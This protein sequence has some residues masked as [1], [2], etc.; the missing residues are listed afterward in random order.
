LFFE[1]S[2]GTPLWLPKCQSNCM[3]RTAKDAR[4]QGGDDLNLYIHHGS[5][6]FRLDIA[7]SLSGKAARE[8]EL[9]W[10][11][12]LSVIGSRV[13]VVAI[14]HVSSLDH[15]G[16]A[17][18]R[19]WQEAGA[20]FVAKSPLAKTLIGSII[21]QPVISGIG[22]VKCDGWARFRA[23]ALPLISL[24]ALFAPA[25][26]AAMLEPAT[27]KA[28]EEY[29]ESAA[30]RMERRLAPGKAFLWVDE[31]SDR[32]ARV[33]AGEIVVSPIGPQNPK[34]VPSGLIHDWVGAVF[35]PHATLKGM[36]QVMRDY[37][38]YKDLYVPSVVDS[39]VIATGEAKDRFSMR[40]AYQSL[41]FKT[42]LDTDYESCYVLVDDRR[43]YS[44][45]RTT[46]IQ[47]I[48]EYGGPAQRTLHEG[49]GIGIIWRLFSVARYSERDGGVYFEV[50]AIG[51]SRDIPASLRWLVEPMV[52]R[53]SRGS[54]ST[55]LR[56]TE[57]A[58]RLLS[59]S[60]GAQKGS[61]PQECGKQI[62][63]GRS[64][65]RY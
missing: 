25:A 8:V 35:I 38:R 11:T 18:L 24:M 36:L 50:E 31:A 44:I 28:W 6:S 43:A 39:K 15:C 48:E 29:V 7:G 56:Q 12:A 34:R 53:V 9:S 23:Y 32:L 1:S 13:I 20:Q 4:R 63:S 55:S 26:N 19:G 47:E 21:G 42:A 16:R 5:S 14:G 17:L 40:L 51:L 57:N 52:R 10:H 27:S 41:L 49:E 62:A 58:V 46:R 45:S 65:H 22:A 64:L 61:R 33:R 3:K 2:E 30:M 54:L 60:S 37:A 59:A